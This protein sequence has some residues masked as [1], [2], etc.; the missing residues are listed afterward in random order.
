MPTISHVSRPMIH[1]ETSPG[2]IE[3]FHEPAGSGKPES[4][5]RGSDGQSSKGTAGPERAGVAS[6]AGGRG[7]SS[8]SRANITGVPDRYIAHPDGEYQT[9]PTN[10]GFFTDSKNQR[11]V[12]MGG[13]LYAVSG[14]EGE[15]TLR[16][17]MPG[18]PAKPGISIERK[19]DGRFGPRDDTGL[20]G[21]MQKGG[22]G[23][24]SPRKFDLQSS[25]DRQQRTLQ[26]AED[27]LRRGTDLVNSG[28]AKVNVLSPQL[29]KARS[30]KSPDVGRLSSE[31]A[32]AREEMRRGRS[33]ASRMNLAIVAAR[34]EIARLER[35]RANQ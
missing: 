2:H 16:V 9:D 26:D 4:V 14:N 5:P 20:K 30:E 6:T 3:P 28:Q 12:S 8:S 1:V 35:E 21:G 31:L 32:S 22:A 29:E 10:P 24:W 34:E 17:V 25:I 15:G 18:E 33:E 23:G 11:Y 27:K 7:P 13:N 19:P